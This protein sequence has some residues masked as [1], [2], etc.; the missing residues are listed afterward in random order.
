MA[1]NQSATRFV[2]LKARVEPLGH[3][4]VRSEGLHDPRG[5]VYTGFSILNPETDELVIVTAGSAKD[6]EVE[7]ETWVVD[8]EEDAARVAEVPRE[9]QALDAK[10]ARLRERQRPG[11]AD[12]TSEEMQT[13]IERVLEERRKLEQQQRWKVFK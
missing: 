2:E 13:V 12:Q 10:V 6:D 4:L 7:V 3:K 8:C 5:N 1:K 11:D 9:I